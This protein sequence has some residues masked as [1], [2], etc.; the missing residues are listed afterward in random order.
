MLL[1]LL[2]LADSALPIGTAAHSFGLETLAADGVVDQDNLGSFLEVLLE[3]SGPMEASFLRSAS[4]TD[5]DTEFWIGL[6]QLMSARKPARE[7]RS[8]SISLGRRFLTLANELQPEE[9]FR[10]ALAATNETHYAPAFGLVTRHIEVS[11][12]SA[13]IA[14]LQQSV[15]SLVSA[16]QR[17]MPLGQ[18]SAARLVWRL[19][20]VVTRVADAS[21][22]T[23]P[24]TVPSFAP[25]AEIGGMRHAGLETRLF[26]S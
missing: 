13:V 24:A 4:R 7:T 8:A 26:V 2:Q 15:M 6:N 23:N 16:S 20:P 3:E 10:S 5:F 17:L 14:Y 18:T 22:D 19:R 1:E 11:E 21:R 9:S 25:L 12:E